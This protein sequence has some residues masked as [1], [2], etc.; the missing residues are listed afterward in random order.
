MV[1]AFWPIA[2]SL[3]DILRDA[4]RFLYRIALPS[5]TRRLRRDLIA[6]TDIAMTDNVRCID[7]LVLSFVVGVGVAMET[8][9]GMI[10]KAL[11]QG[12]ESC[13]SG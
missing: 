10:N 5:A 9:G 4:V 3:S 8:F 7:L 1:Q 12:P 2:Y 6:M 11:L 13:T